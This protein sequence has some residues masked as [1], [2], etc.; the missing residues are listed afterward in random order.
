MVMGSSCI[1]LFSHELSGLMNTLATSISEAGR[2]PPRQLSDR[3]MMILVASIASFPPLSTDLY[4]PALPT[5]K[6]QLHCSGFLVN[7]SLVV[8]FIVVSISSLL[9]GPLSDK[10]GRKRI[11][12]IGIPLYVVASVFCVFSQNVVQLIAARIFQATGAGAAMAVTMAIVKDVFPGKKREHALALISVLNGFI[13]VLAPSVGSFI[14]KL[15][16]WRGV[17]GLLAIIGALVFVF[18]LFLKETSIEHAHLSIFQT[19][20]RLL[21]VLKNPNFSRLIIVFS[22]VSIPILGFI[23]VSSFIFIKH[24][25]VS[26]EAFGI[27]F[28]AVSVLF[29]IGGPIYLFLQKFFKPLSIITVCYVGSLISG[30]LMLTIGQ[31]GPMLFSISIACSY[32]FVSISRPPSSSLLLEQQNK[33]TGS[34]SSL[35]QASFLLAGSMGMLFVSYDWSNR[36]TVLG[37]MNLILGVGGLALWIYTKKRCRIPKHFA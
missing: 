17:F 2:K 20:S 5:M 26:K 3:M 7:L 25:G 15:I 27:Y 21:V 12:M 23:S 34:A 6:E 8:F 35:I 29:I 37:L 16:S 32:F 19:T 28:G 4:L 11:L 1:Y 31:M 18:V 33:D 22:L 30:V 10:Y 9:W 14:L 24:F 36:I 13:P